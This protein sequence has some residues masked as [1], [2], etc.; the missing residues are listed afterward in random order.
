MTI[1]LAAATPLRHV[2]AAPP[3]SHVEAAPP[4][5]HVEAAAPPPRHVEAAAAAAEA[6][7]A[8]AAAA[9][10]AAAP[11][12][13]P[14]PPPQVEA[15]LAEAATPP[16]A[17]VEAA[18]LPPAQAEAAPHPALAEEAAASDV[19]VAAMPAA[20]NLHAGLQHGLLSA[21]HRG[22]N[23]IREQSPQPEE[24]LLGV[25]E[26]CP[27]RYASVD[28]ATSTPWTYMNGRLGGRAPTAAASLRLSLRPFL[29]TIFL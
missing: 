24:L 21:Q 19:A 1:A 15:A 11:A 8:E 6:A 7:A 29:Q 25:E 13:P 22:R 28:G 10:A 9:E 18:L 26:L 27:Q 4:P 16:S 23:R 2:E 3:P 5:P 17:Q 14:P 12:P 20:N